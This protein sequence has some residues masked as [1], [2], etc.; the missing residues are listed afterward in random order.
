[1][2]DPGYAF[3]FT[4]IIRIVPVYHTPIIGFMWGGMW[5][6]NWQRFVIGTGVSRIKISDTLANKV[7]FLDSTR[8]LI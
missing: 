7:V 2:L 4:A 6:N 5:I 3:Y 1:M 8:V